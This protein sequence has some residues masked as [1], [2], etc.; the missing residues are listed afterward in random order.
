[1]KQVG[2]DILVLIQDRARFAVRSEITTALWF[3]ADDDLCFPVEDQID[4]RIGFH[5]RGQTTFWGWVNDC[6]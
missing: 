3:E 2:K 5:I 4:S 6:S 1:M